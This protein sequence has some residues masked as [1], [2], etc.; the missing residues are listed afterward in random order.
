M[1]STARLRPLLGI[2]HLFVSS[3][4]NPIYPSTAR[5][6]NEFIYPFR[7]KK[8]VPRFYNH[9]LVIILWSFFSISHHHATQYVLSSSIVAS[10]SDF[11]YSGPQFLL[12][13]L[14]RVGGCTKRL[15]FF[16]TLINYNL[17]HHV[18]VS[19]RFRLSLGVL[20]LRV[21]V[22]S[23]HHFKLNWCRNNF[24]SRLINHLSI[25]NRENNL[26]PSLD[27]SNIQVVNLLAYTLTIH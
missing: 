7:C 2:G 18:R 9:F 14:Y 5:N 6:F 15:A 3:T 25:L 1:S 11:L 22:S 19:T 16:Q 17:F 20:A 23:I 26:L 13:T 27:Y 24:N 10:L 21:T 4:T 12:L 8:D